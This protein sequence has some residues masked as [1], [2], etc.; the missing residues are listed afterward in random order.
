MELQGPATALDHAELAD[1]MIRAAGG[2]VTPE[3]ETELQAA[4]K[5]DPALGT[6]RF[7]AGLLE[8]QTGR[9]DRAFAFWR[10]LLEDSSPDAPW[11]AFLGEQLPLV[12]EAA[13]VAYA[14]PEARGPSAADVAVAGEKSAEDRAAMIAGMVDGLEARLMAEGGSAGEW[15][16]LLTALGVLNEPARRAAALAR[17]EAAHAG[18]PQALAAIRAAAGAGP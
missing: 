3:A 4:L 8:A 2:I 12:A 1:L 6:V 7:Y 5:L 16:Q 18:D 17:A 15:A 13:G 11:M 10:P 9:P 14:P